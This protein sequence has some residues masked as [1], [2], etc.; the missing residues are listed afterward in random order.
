MVK[1]MLSRIRAVFSRKTLGKDVVAG[2]VL[3][4]ESVPDGLSA[5]LL[6]GV[7]P[8]A[9]LYAYLF[10]MV[11]AAA[12]TSSTFMAVQATGAMALIVGDANLNARPDPDRA[13]FTLALL[14]GVVLVIAGLLKAGR[15]VRFV[16][17]AVMTGFLTAVGVN[18]IL[19]QLANFTGFDAEGSSRIA[20]SLDTVLNIGQWS[21]P[22]VVTG[23]IT[24]LII[25]VLASTR[26][27]SLGLVVAVVV[28]S[29]VAVVLNLWVSAP[30]LL[31]RDIVE[32]P[33]G[34]PAPVLPV[35]GD[36]PALIVP[37]LSLALVCVI[38]GAGVSA[39]LPTRDGR[40][41]DPS[42][43]V[44]GQGIGN[45]L[46]GLF[47]GMPVG[48]SMSA[49]ALL[50]QAGARTRLSLFISGVV[51]ALVIVFA[52]ETVAFTAMP[53]LAGLLM[54]IGY[55]S[56]NP[57]RIR[58]VLKTGPVQ[59]TNM[60]VTFTLTLILPLQFAVLA[61]AGVGIILFVVQ[62][63]NRIR[64]RQVELQPDGHVRERDP[65]TTIP[66]RSVVILQP[67]GSLFFATAPSFQEQLPDVGAHS[68]HSV[69]IIRLRGTDEVGL[70]ILEALTRY[71]TQLHD[72]E[73]TLKIVASEPRVITQIRASGLT[74]V[75]GERNLY[76]GGEWVGTAL[77][78][79]DADARTEIG[80]HRNPAS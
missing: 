11:G 50:V 77:R 33:N 18:I 25:V 49:S 24:I 38:Q 53:A 72:V 73:S 79:A 2:V 30:V 13:L 68:V 31:L 7:N 15:L 74:A 1:G 47:Q 51:M 22:A 21:V 52:A 71:A 3:G 17:T 61:G 46:S 27:G 8:L 67:Y 76:Q 35:I 23:V 19:G 48:G 43:D 5:G 14:T 66:P 59:V 37:A 69:V 75:I 16:P 28:G 39:G 63:S 12:F 26:V 42:R 6:A 62:K 36:V 29:A 64:F 65:I 34:L 78:H 45:L 4:V 56:I 70:A 9:G 41:P 44:V 40:T 80:E 20:R 54:V 60:A 10:G 55:L 58:S 32:V 57:G